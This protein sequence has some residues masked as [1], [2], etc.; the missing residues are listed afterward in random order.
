MHLGSA[1]LVTF[2]Y[3]AAPVAGAAVF[4]VVVGVPLWLL[5]VRELSVRVRWDTEGIKVRNR[6]RSRRLPWRDVLYCDLEGRGSALLP[7]RMLVLATVIGP[8]PLVATTR[9]GEAWYVNP[10]DHAAK[11][12]ALRDRFN[13]LAT[14][15]RSPIRPT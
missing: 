5:A 3:V 1:I 15:A 4:F 11:L 8:I 9:A 7:R 13:Q 2:A 10:G 12:E 14:A 6:L